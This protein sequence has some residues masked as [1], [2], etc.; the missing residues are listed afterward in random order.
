MSKSRKL[1]AVLE[2]LALIRTAPTTEAA[3]TELGQILQS[4]HAVAIAQAA[5]LIGESELTMLIPNLVQAFDRCLQNPATT[6]PNCHAKAAIADALYRMEAREVSLFLRGIRHVQ[7]EPVWG[8]QVDTAVKLRGTC[9]LGLVRSNY[10]D[11]MTELA[12]LLADPESPARIASARAIAYS[13]NVQGIP[14]LRLRVLAGD[15]PSVISECVAAMLK[16]DPD[17]S[18]PFA[19]PLLQAPAVQ[20]QELVALVLG[21]ARLPAA[22]EPLK[23]WWGKQS[24]L[25]LR[26][27]ALLAIA[28]LRSDPALSFLLTLISQGRPLD[29]KQAIEALKI[30][31]QDAHLWPLVQQA[32][33]QR[34][35]HST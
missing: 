30:Y 18:L 19:F 1:E 14:L 2:R 5:K 26:Q 21:E 33:T 4:K 34:N 7:M 24:D 8:G 25:E 11:V 29:A 28:M 16:L 3:M 15:E 23:S 6:D 9:A 20:T 27:T 35:N 22:F 32:M 13:E 10:P 17:R 31:Q 12:D